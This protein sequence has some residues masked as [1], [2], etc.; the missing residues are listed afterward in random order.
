MGRHNR[1]GRGTDQASREYEISYPPD[2]LSHVKVT[3]LLEHGRQSTMTLFR[4]PDP[5]RKGPGKQVKTRIR[6]DELGLDVEV[7]LKDPGDQVV[8]VAV[9]TA[10]PNAKGTDRSITLT[11]NAH[12][13]AE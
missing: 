6:C 7:V 8:R 10:P 1:D 3:R 11:L 12:G 2:W 5:P 13:Q 9:E 4:N